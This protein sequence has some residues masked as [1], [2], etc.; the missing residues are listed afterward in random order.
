MPHLFPALIAKGIR[1]TFPDGKQALKPLDLTVEP[2]AIHVLLGLSGAGKSTLARILD[3]ELHAQEGTLHI[4]GQL[5]QPRSRQEAERAGIVCVPQAVDVDLHASVYDALNIGPVPRR[6]GFVDHEAMRKTA[7]AHLEQWGMGHLDPESQFGDLLP[8]QQKLLQIAGKLHQIGA[9]LVLDDPCACL[10]DAEAGFLYQKLSQMKFA[11]MG[12]VY[13]TSSPTEALEVGDY[14]SVMRDGSL[15]TT[16]FH[17]DVFVHQL[18]GEMVGRDDSRIPPRKPRA[19]GPETTLRL[20]GISAGPKLVSVSLKLKRGEIHGLA[21]LAQ[22]GQSHFVRAAAGYEPRTGGNVFLRGSGIPSSTST[23]ERSFVSGLGFVPDPYGVSASSAAAPSLQARTFLRAL[24]LANPVRAGVAKCF[25][26]SSC[27]ILLDEPFHGLTTASRFEVSEAIQD[28]AETG[29][30]VLIASTE[31]DEL[32]K[33]CDR[34]SLMAIGRILK[35]VDRR[36]FDVY[37]M[38]KILKNPTA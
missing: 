37:R 24:S 8:G 15:L 38:A 32:I 4:N 31:L 35:T 13:V 14:I 18:V 27:A 6:F 29:V 17:E 22:G 16:H 12:I 3:G 10:T 30:C 34:I 20:E 19:V 5:T 25:Q 23:L 26:N 21:G 1:Y 9:L 11:Q 33:I 2:G 28:I 36:E 7:A